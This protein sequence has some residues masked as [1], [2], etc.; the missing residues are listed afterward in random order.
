MNS[1]RLISVSCIVLILVVSFFMLRNQS[2]VNS[3]QQH[4]KPQ[5]SRSV[6]VGA[7]VEGF[8]DNS[9]KTLDTSV[10]TD[11]EEVLDKKM[12]IAALYSEWSYLSHQDLLLAL[13][14]VSG[15][16]WVPMI[17]A[18]P[19]FFEGCPEKDA[20]LYQAIGRGDCDAF[21]RDIGRNFRS[22]GK[23]ILFRF[24]W[25]MN[26]PDMYWSVSKV[27]STPQEFINAWR[28]LHTILKEE[29]AMNVQ[30]V[31]SFNTSHAKTVPYAD[32]YP[33]DS[34][35]DWVAIDGYNWGNSQPWGGWADF[36]G[37]FRKS[38]DELI[39]ITDKPVMLSEVNS[40]PSGGNK[41]Q[42]LED[43]LT[44][45]IPGRFP[46]VKA[47]VFFNENKTD[48]EQVDWRLEKSPEY[49]N[50]VKSSLQNVLYK[51]AFP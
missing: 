17:S 33:G 35:V 50:V 8:W 15:K 10:L 51:S 1:I 29:E 22:Y 23:T 30:F 13:N 47:L 46:Q 16:G 9:D 21:I 48:G 7:W 40:S 31:L 20:S 44:V 4:V 32:L 37:V 6:Y 26:L 14:D 45:Q 38:Y 11:F 34:Y 19:Y 42:W 5:E 49:I 24:A 41:A 28:R 39:V 43:M 12:A 36:N 27:K 18:N 25:E 3:L 2:Q